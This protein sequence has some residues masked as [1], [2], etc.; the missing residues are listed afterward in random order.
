MIKNN[1]RI[2]GYWGRQYPTIEGSKIGSL[3]FE[4]RHSVE[5]VN[6]ELFFL[7]KIYCFGG[8]KRFNP[9]LLV[10][11]Q[12]IG[13]EMICLMSDKN[14]RFEVEPVELPVNTPIGLDKLKNALFDK[15]NKDD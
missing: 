12:K 7:G 1:C 2:V 4:R 5:S 10:V 6:F 11:S 9:E 14:I 3:Y 13:K 15:K 8:K